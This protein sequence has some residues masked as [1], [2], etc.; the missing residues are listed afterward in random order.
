MYLSSSVSQYVH[1][2]D[3]LKIFLELK[4]SHLCGMLKICMKLKLSQKQLINKQQLWGVGCAKARCAN[5]QQP[6]NP[7]YLPSF[8]LRLR[9]ARLFN[10]TIS[11]GTTGSPCPQKDI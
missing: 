4:I 7:L 10:G 3:M 8:S 11:P 5:R 9:I 6:L 2:C 1:L